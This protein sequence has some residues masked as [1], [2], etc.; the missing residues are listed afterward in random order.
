MEV[1]SARNPTD[2]QLIRVVDRSFLHLKSL[3]IMD[4]K[5]YL[6]DIFFLDVLYG[7]YRLDIQKNQDIAIT[8]RYDKEG[9]FKF[10]V[11]SDD[12]EN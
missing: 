2:L 3:T 1:F 10:G 11:Y 4:L 12:L 5:I 9:F 8:A 7:L 6:G